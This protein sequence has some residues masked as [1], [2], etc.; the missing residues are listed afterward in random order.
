VFTCETHRVI[1]WS[2]KKWHY[3]SKK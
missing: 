2:F 1:C 3:A